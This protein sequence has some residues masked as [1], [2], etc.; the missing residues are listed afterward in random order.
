MRVA[1]HR[2]VDTV[3]L[4]DG[5][6]NMQNGILHPTLLVLENARHEERFPLWLAVLL[7]KAHCN[8]RK[9]C[10]RT[11]AFV[12]VADNGKP[13]HHSLFRAFAADEFEG[14]SVLLRLFEGLLLDW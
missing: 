12:W 14:A 7:W 8:N 9:R 6:A 4:E 2:G 11:T 13:V 1:V 5:R 3:H 10:P